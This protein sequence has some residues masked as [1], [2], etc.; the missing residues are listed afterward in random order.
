MADCTYTFGVEYVLG[1]VDR[2]QNPL[3]VAN[4]TLVTGR[5]AAMMTFS[6]VTTRIAMIRRERMHSG[7]N[8]RTPFIGRCVTSGAVV[9]AKLVHSFVAIAANVLQT[10]KLGL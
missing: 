7:L 2:L 9:V 6:A 1:L 3:I 8:T 4:V 5:V 10:H